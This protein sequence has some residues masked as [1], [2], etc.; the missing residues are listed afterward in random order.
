MD[1]TYRDLGYRGHE[2]EHRYGPRV[3]ILH[4]PV[5]LSLLARL[6]SPQT[7]QPA[8]NGYVKM[9]YQT[10]VDTVVNAEFPRRRVTVTSR[11]A[12]EV[13][14]GVFETELIDPDCETVTVDIARAGIL[15]SHICFER[16][17]HILNAQGVRQD[18][19]IMSRVTNQ[20][21]AVTGA[22]IG[23]HKIGGPVGG[24]VVLFPD[25]MG[26]TG[27]SLATAIDFYKRG[28]YGTPLKWITLNLIITPEF[29]RNML[30]R[31]PDV[32]LY[33][34]R[35]DRGLS[36][37]DVLQTIPGT[38]WAEERGLTDKH[39]IVPGAGGLGEI[40]NNAFV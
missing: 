31:H 14:E 36:A 13:P 38:R 4:H 5:A 17:N 20:A 23:G 34:F 29:I 1:V 27:S 16:L 12:T 32:T 26:A 8:T 2:I 33:A 28:G 18:H 11:M 10:L 40:L 19:L 39:Y 35:L 6:G 22:G 15:P 25:P 24:S 3:H 37:P 30:E 21:H 9:L 7:V